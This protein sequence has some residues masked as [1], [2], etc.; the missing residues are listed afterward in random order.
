M[1][2]ALESRTILR[3]VPIRGRRVISGL[4]CLLLLRKNVVGLVREGSSR[5]GKVA[6]KCNRDEFLAN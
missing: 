6:L 5:I 1:N 4:M 3:A 2:G